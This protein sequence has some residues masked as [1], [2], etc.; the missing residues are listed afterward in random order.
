MKLEPL[1]LIP[2]EPEALDLSQM[3]DEEIGWYN[4][5]QALVYEKI[6]PH[7][8]DEESAWLKEVTKPVRR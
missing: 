3:T 8:T 6:A 5:Y 4:E 1:T 7:L 2:Y